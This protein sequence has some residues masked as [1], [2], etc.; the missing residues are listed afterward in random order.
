M[1]PSELQPCLS[2]REIAQQAMSRPYLNN[3][4]QLVSAPHDVYQTL[5]EATLYRFMEFCQ[6]MPLEMNLAP[7]SLLHKHLELAVAV[8][9]LRRGYML[10][11]NADSEAIAEQEPL[12]TYALFSLALLERLHHLQEDRSVDL[13]KNPNERIGIWHPFVG[14]LYEPDTYYQ[15]KSHPQIL[16][17]PAKTLQIAIARKMIPSVAM[18]WLSGYPDIFH[19]WFAALTQENEDKNS[20]AQIIRKAR[21]VLGLAA[22]NQPEPDNTKLISLR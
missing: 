4:Q 7:Y 8:L 22:S 11:T 18:R 9:K 10:P 14:R 13:Y 16:R 3:I 2:G 15:L 5:Y 20:L 6:A 19:D 17:V 1:L 21:L 12:W